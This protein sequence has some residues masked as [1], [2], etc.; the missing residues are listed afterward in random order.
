MFKTLYKATAMVVVTTG[1][2]FSTPTT[3][4]ANWQKWKKCEAD[5]NNTAAHY[6]RLM[7]AKQRQID[8]IMKRAQQKEGEI[9]NFNALEAKTFHCKRKMKRIRI[10]LPAFKRKMVRIRVKI[11]KIYRKRR[12]INFKCRPKIYRKR[13]CKRIKFG[14]GSKRI[15]FHV[16]KIVWARC[17]KISFKS[18]TIKWRYKEIKFKVPGVR[19]KYKDIKFKVPACYN[20]KSHLKKK[21]QQLNSL[22]NEAQQVGKELSRLSKEMDTKLT[23][24]QRR[25]GF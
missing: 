15:C 7:S 5:M 14:I 19:W 20:T 4:S 6:Q 16:P 11:P 22:A 12:V 9:G 8:S 25:C 21:E 10:K 1:L 13:V 17:A 3:A 2:M 24:I 23:A 18:P